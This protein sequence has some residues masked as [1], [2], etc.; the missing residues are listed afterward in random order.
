MSKYV[1]YIGRSKSD[2]KYSRR[3]NVVMATIDKFGRKLIEEGPTVNAVRSPACNV[4]FTQDRQLNAQNL[5]LKN[6]RD[7]ID[8]CDAVNKQFLK[9]ELRGQ[10]EDVK[11]GLEG[12]HE[13]LTSK[14]EHVQVELTHLKQL[15]NSAASSAAGSRTKNTTAVKKD[16]AQGTKRTT[17][18]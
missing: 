16:V 5:R 4:P 7:P 11:T 2:E 1:L 12:A 18:A 3:G 14:I 17:S 8:D 13:S 6:L 15:L 10:I 9:L